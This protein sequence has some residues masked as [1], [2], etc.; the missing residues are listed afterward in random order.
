MVRTAHGKT[1]TMFRTST[2]LIA[3]IILFAAGG[4]IRAQTPLCGMG[5]SDWCPAP[6]GDPCGAHR[7]TAQCK[8]DPRCYGMPYRGE[9]VVPCLFDERGFASNC[10]TVGCTGTRPAGTAPK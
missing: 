7:N 8:A 1:Q 3:A 10:P 5:L 9:S 6:P 4:D 2:I